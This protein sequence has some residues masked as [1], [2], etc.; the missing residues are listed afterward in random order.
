MTK[1]TKQKPIHKVRIGSIVACVW[2]NETEHGPR[3]NVTVERLS[4]RVG[5]MVNYTWA[6]SLDNSA[7]DSAARAFFRGVDAHSERGPSDFDAL[8][9][10][11]SNWVYQL[12]F[13]SGKRWG[14]GM[15]GIAE[16]MSD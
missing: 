13:G 6:K 8:H 15:R 16:A 5:A 12:P 9:Q 2:R 3:F 1:E 10:I 11:N 4:R 14:A 7:E